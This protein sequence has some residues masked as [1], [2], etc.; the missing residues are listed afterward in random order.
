MLMG[1]AYTA[2][3]NVFLLIWL[4]NEEIDLVNLCSRGE[5]VLYPKTNNRTGTVGQK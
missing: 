4:K 1:N 5:H 2:L 3:G